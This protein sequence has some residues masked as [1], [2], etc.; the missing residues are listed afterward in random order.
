MLALPAAAVTVN[1]GAPSAPPA[2]QL[3]RTLGAAA[4]RTLPGSESVNAMP[5]CA[6]LPVP[7][8]SVNASVEV[9]PAAMLVGLNTLSRLAC[10]TLSICGVTA[11]RTPVVVI[12]AAS[13]VFAPRVVPRTVNVITHVCPAFTPT[14][15]APGV[16]EAFAVPESAGETQPAL[17]AAAGGFATSSPAGSASPNARPERL[18]APALLSIVNASVVTWPMPRLDTPK[19]LVSVGSAC[20]TSCAET[21][22][23]ARFDAPE[24]LAASVF[25]YVPGADEVTSTRISQLATPALSAAPLTV[26][27]PALVETK[28]GPA[29]SAP[30]AGQLE[31]RFATAATVT[32][33]GSVSTKPTPD[34]AGFVPLLV[35]VKTSVDVPPWSMVDG[36]NDFASVGLERVTTRHWSV[37]TLFDAVVVTFVA[38]FVKAAGLPAQLGFTCDAAFV[39]PESV[40]VQ[41]AV[42]AVIAIPVRPESTRDPAL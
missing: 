40:T 39:S 22:V 27:A 41:L 3:L 30:P 42:P 14:L 4:T 23:V 25:V 6:G 29:T 19:A 2:G 21:P 16:V 5:D 17:V 13:L 24:R 20:T 28:A 12:A 11:F 35:T 34:C 8:V 18:T 1:A 36:E 15:E 10:T 31:R 37:E 26:T 38:A 9:P 7:F 32:P 33:G